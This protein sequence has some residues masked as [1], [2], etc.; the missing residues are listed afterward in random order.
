MTTIDVP[1]AIGSVDRPE[2]SPADAESLASTLLTNAARM[3]EFADEAEALATHNALW[4][5]EASAA[6]SAHASAFATRHEPMATT[7]KRVARGVDVFAEQLRTL[8]SDHTDLTGEITTYHRDRNDLITDVNA[9]QDVTESE[10]GALQERARVLTTQRSGLV[11]EIVSFTQRVT[12]NEDFLVQLFTGADTAAEAGEADGGIDPLAL[13]A[14]N[15]M[16]SVEDGPEKM[17]AWWEG[18]SEAEQD[19]LTAAYPE[20]LGSADGLPAWARDDANRLLLDSDLAD[21]RAKEEDGTLTETEKQRLVNAE[22]A[23]A[24][25]R[26]ADTYVVPGTDDKPGGMLWLYDPDAFGGDGRVAIAVGDLDTADDVSIQIPGIRTEMDDTAD[27]VQDATDLYESARYIGDGSTVATMFWLGYN[28]P[29]GDLLEWGEVPSEHYAVDGGERLA[30]AVD[31]LRASRADNPA[32][33][34]AIGHSYGSTATSYAAA[35][36]DLAV[37]DIALVG[38]PGTGPADD[39]SDFS[40]GAD[41]VYVGRNS[42]DLVATLGDEGWLNK[43]PIGLGVDPSSEE[44]DAQRFRAEDVNRQRNEG[45]VKGGH[46]DGPSYNFDDHVKYFDRDSESLYN[47]GRIVDGHGDDINPA[48]NSYDPFWELPQDPES[49]R[50]PTQGVPGESRTGLSERDG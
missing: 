34:T 49:D 3:N 8:K 20:R 36:H 40:V 29:A 28:T 41:H 26:T 23:E 17:A 27:Y 15:G 13:T 4:V 14:I 19:A 1:A 11:S 43:H 30:A 9:A 39:A 50:T 25:L 2:G 33:M 5:G 44:F 6:Y 47:L 48:K 31:G 32:H 12:A 18:L 10:I 16:P 46:Y 45:V 7:L 22:A 42:S 24:A 35:E 21:L 38:S 37:D